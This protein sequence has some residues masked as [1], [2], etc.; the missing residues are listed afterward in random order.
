VGSYAIYCR[1]RS[2]LRLATGQALRFERAGGGLPSVEVRSRYL[3][4]PTD[5]L[6]RDLLIEV[7]VD[8]ENLESAANDGL[9]AAASQLLPLAVAANAFVANPVLVSAYATSPGL[10]EREWVQRR[11]PV[12]ESLPPNSREITAH[13]AGEFM[14][15][16]EHHSQRARF[17]RV[18][19]FYREALRYAETDSAL[20]AVEFLHIAA[21]T[22]T[23]VLLE[24]DNGQRK[25]SGEEL[26]RTRL[27][28]IYAG[29]SEL[30]K[31]V[32]RLSNGFE[33]GYED[34]GT[35][36]DV[37]R[38]VVGEASKSIRTAI[39][40]ASGVS[41]A[42][43]T[44]LLAARFSVPMPLFDTEYL[45]VGKL[46]IEE[47]A[48]LAPRTEPIVALRDWEVWPESSERHEDG[49]LL[50]R[51]AGSARASDPGATVTVEAVVQRL[52]VGLPAGARMPEHRITSIHV[53]E[54]D[55]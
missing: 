17:G 24:R 2:A 21:E 55:G 4:P 19:A 46:R 37:A 43:L 31:R 1:C 27:E 30:R 13:A 33:H 18:L 9:Q 49:S 16:T 10:R 15:A 11:Q 20:L 32:E 52:P 6:A 34:L 44:E 41:H 7:R 29:D 35:A 28:K 47:S 14:R 50:V 54:K 38:A 39:L 40:L 23:P 51:T 5:H 45:Y 36:K 22:L 48:R 8:A 53:V 42:A 26:R 3:P 25:A 12:E